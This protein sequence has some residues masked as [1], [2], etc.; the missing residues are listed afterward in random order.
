MSERLSITFTING[1]RKKFTSDLAFF[2]CNLAINYKKIGNCLL[3]YTANINIF[4]L[5]DK[6]LTTDGKSFFL[7]PFAVNI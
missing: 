7:W 1:D 6:Q 2:S 5:L 3:L 4:T